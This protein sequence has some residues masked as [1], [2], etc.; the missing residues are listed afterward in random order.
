MST[1][2]VLSGGSNLGSAQVGMLRALFEAGIVPSSITGTSAGAI[3]AKPAEKESAR[4][5]PA[6]EIT[7]PKTSP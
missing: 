4:L 3:V 2:F 5:K 7:T 6:P 1:A